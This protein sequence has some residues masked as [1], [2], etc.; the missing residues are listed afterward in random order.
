MTTC[1]LGADS[2]GDIDLKLDHHGGMRTTVEGAV[3][4]HVDQLTSSPGFRWLEVGE[5]SPE[6]YDRFIA[7]V[8][9]THVKSPQVVAF[10]YA[11]APPEATT[12]LLHN[13]L[14]EVGIEEESG[15][16]HPAMLGQLAAGAGL[17]PVLPELE[18]LAAEDLRSIASEP[19][20]YGALKEVGLAALCEVVAFEFMLSRVASRVERA[21]EV[22]RGLTPE[23][24]EWFRHHSEVDIAHAEQGLQHIEDYVHHY[25]I[26]DDDAVSIIEL[27]LRENV[28]IRRYFTQS[29]PITASSLG[30]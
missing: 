30:G 18:R 4:D 13:L 15:V 20:L 23:A 1:R 10:L 9:R 25:A 26:G 17:A 8:I 6:E 28:F 7:N 2:R 24:L 27:T 19:L 5:A 21:L 11:L 14:E 29:S 12:D 3:S 22:H 16:A